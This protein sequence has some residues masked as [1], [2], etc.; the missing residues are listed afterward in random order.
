V[1]ADGVNIG[2]HGTHIDGHFSGRLHAVGMERD[3]GHLR[4]TANLLDGL[5]GAQFVVYVH[6][7]DQLRIRP[8]RAANR[9]RIDNAAAI[10]R[11]ASDG[12]LVRGRK[13]SGMFDGRR[14]YMPARRDSQDREIVRFRAP[15]GENNLI[16]GATEH[17]RDLPPRVVE[18][19]A[20]RL[21]IM[22]DTGGVAEN[23]SHRREHGF[24]HFRGHGRCRVVIEIISLHGFL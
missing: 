17:R 18:F 13:N 4:D 8:Q 16:V 7:R 6:H 23:L 1:T 22:V 15:A 3:T 9:I 12:A 14:D 20:G 21:S 2:V 5:Y 10:Y 24:Q 11:D 19:G